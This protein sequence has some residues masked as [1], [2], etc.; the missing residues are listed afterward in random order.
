MYRRRIKPDTRPHWNDD[1]KISFRGVLYTADEWQKMCAR[2]IA[3][4]MTPNYK[5]DPTYNLKVKRER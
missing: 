4:D 3:T 1:L 5:N 2:A